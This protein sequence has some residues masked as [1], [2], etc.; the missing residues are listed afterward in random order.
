MKFTEVRAVAWV[1]D[2]VRV[3][4]GEVGVDGVDLFWFLVMLFLIMLFLIMLLLI[5]GRGMACVVCLH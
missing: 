2:E 4:D 1:G 5:L 3:G